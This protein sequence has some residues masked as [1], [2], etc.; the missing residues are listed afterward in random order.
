MERFRRQHRF[1]YH[2]LNDAS[3]VEKLISQ[4]PSLEQNDLNIAVINFID[5]L[6]HSRTENKMIRELASTEAAYRSITLSW[7]KHSPMSELFKKLAERKYTVVITTDHGSIR[8]NN[9][10]KVQSNGKEVNAN[11]RYK[12]SRNISY[13]PKQVYEVTTPKEVALP[14]P[15][16]STR[17]IFATGKDFFAYPNNYN[18]YELLYRHVSARRYIHGR[19]AHPAHNHAKRTLNRN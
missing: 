3:G 4:L 17:Y 19:D 12:L 18:H 2:K 7:Y 13:N 14:C 1:S 8:V 15:N 6:S 10:V 5:M 16:V 9:P 11:L